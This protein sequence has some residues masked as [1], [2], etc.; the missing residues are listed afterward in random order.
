MQGKG[1]SRRG[2]LKGLG[3]SVT[4]G[5]LAGPSDAIAM[6][7]GEPASALV[8]PQVHHHPL[9]ELDIAG[10]RD[11]EKWKAVPDGIHGSFASKDE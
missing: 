10:S 4:V 9:V 3:A 1:S 5:T 8:L 7:G 6:Q 2:F 11:S